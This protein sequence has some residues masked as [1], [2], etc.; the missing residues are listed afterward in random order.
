MLHVIVTIHHKL[1]L[2]DAELL[3]SG[4]CEVKATDVCGLQ[5]FAW[6]QDRY[7]LR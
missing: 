4:I 1:P 6:G 5:Q 3:I 2:H 7:F